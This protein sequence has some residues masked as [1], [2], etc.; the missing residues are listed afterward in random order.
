[1]DVNSKSFVSYFAPILE[2]KEN[3]LIIPHKNPDGDAIGSTTALYNYLIEKN[4]NPTILINDAYPYFLD[5]V[6]GASSSIIYDNNPEGCI[7]KFKSTD[8][9]F[10]LDY[11][12]TH[13]S[14]ELQKYIDAAICTKVVI[15]HHPDFEEAFDF[16]YHDTAASSTCEL[17][18]LFIKE[19][20]R[21]NKSYKFSKT[22]ATCLYTGLLTDTGGFKHAL[23]PQTMIA[24]AE[25]LETGISYESIISK[26]WDV[27]TPEKL[28]LIGFSLNE[29]LVIL[30]EYRTAYIYLTA[31]DVQ[32][33]GIKKGDTEGLV[34]YTLSI[35]NIVLGVFFHEKEDGTTK[36]SFRSKSSFAV[37]ELS[38]KYF[39]GGG[40]KN[41]AGGS[42][43][44]N[45]N[46]T[47]TK[48]LEIL[49]Q[50]QDILNSLVIGEK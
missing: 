35:E 23:R 19:L 12:Q 26:I 34:S 29:R 2:Q 47:V 8:L 14:G 15:D 37:N 5:F 22:V 4:K 43:S 18:Y 11:S 13:R 36:I 25:L 32:K 30:P 50:Y 39:H 7:E 20:E 9:I 49:P 45:V 28:K 10:C 46:R 16:Y 6:P 1:M 44:E 48:F 3:I 38:G 21:D 31:N 27:N 17:V 24:A 41:A 40:H 33:L 42:S